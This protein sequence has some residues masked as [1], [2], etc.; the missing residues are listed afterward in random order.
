MIISILTLIN[1]LLLT[2]CIIS[3]PPSTILIPNPRKSNESL[4]VIL[5]PMKQVIPN[6]H[7]YSDGDTE[8]YDRNSTGRNYMKNKRKHLPTRMIEN[9]PKERQQDFTIE[10]QQEHL[11]PKE[12]HLQMHSE[13]RVQGTNSTNDN[14]PKSDFT[15]NINFQQTQLVNV[16]D[17]ISESNSKSNLKVLFYDPLSLQDSI[18]SRIFDEDGN[19]VNLS[20]QSVLLMP[21]DKVIETKSSDPN[22]SPKGFEQQLSPISKQSIQKDFTK[23]RRNHPKDN[24]ILF[25]TI[26][27]MAVFV[28]ALTGKRIRKSC[29]FLKYFIESE[30]EEE[31]GEE[32]IEDR[33]SILMGRDYD[34]FGRYAGDIRWRGDLEKFDV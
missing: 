5:K 19:M 17:S 1:F 34:T 2:T 22:S 31:D 6:F 29:N 3:N 12:A 23:L 25:G 4:S 27:T 21:P 28:G 24:M 18:P 7:H 26:L 14:N 30:S 20:G 9:L 33:E 8:T 32:D 13:K 15:S 16:P 11:L 10:R